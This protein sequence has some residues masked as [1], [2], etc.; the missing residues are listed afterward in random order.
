MAK[1]TKK[2]RAVV[3]LNGSPRPKG[4]TAIVAGWLEGALVEAGWQVQRYDL[5]GMKYRGCAH[6]DTC[7]EAGDRPG[8]GLRDEFAPVLDRIAAADAIV[9]ASPVYCWSI[10][11]CASAAL[12]RFYSLFK[13]NRSLVK[14]KKI[15]GVF[16]A[17]GDAFDG[18]DLCVE[19]LKRIAEYGGAEY[20]GTL[21]AD[22]CGTPK[23]TRER[24]DLRTAAIALAGAL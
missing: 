4:N 2:D 6:C 11:G 13:E 16:S 20:E 3:I 7:R 14:G 9:L 24:K 23:E 19:M 1:T 5:Y 22:W 8:C 12:D 18:M 15:A 10:S 17:A 21:C